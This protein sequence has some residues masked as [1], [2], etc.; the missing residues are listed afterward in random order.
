M[1]MQIWT[2]TNYD[3]H[4]EFPYTGVFKDRGEALKHIEMKWDM[5]VDDYNFL[6]DEDISTPELPEPTHTLIGYLYQFCVDPSVQDPE[7]TVL[8]SH[9]V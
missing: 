9:W 2:V 5:Y 8:E 7:Y 3:V 6:T 1:D 4:L